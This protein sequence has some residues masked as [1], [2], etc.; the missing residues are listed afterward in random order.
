MLP[1]PPPPPPVVVPPPPPVVVPPPPPPVVT[2]V[3]V[4]VTP[5]MPL[6]GIVQVDAAAKVGAKLR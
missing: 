6:T 1:P 2:A 3:K 5:V 4:A